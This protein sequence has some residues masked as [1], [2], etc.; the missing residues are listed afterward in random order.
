MTYITGSTYAVRNEL[1]SLGCKWDAN[2]KAWY[3]P[4]NIPMGQVRRIETEVYRLRKQ[5]PGLVI[6]R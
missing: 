2:R 5:A 6:G 4:D 1:K 3:I